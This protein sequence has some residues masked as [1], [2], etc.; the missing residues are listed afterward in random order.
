M[1]CFFFCIEFDI[2]FFC[3]T[4]CRIYS[5]SYIHSATSSEVLHI[6]LFASFVYCPILFPKKGELF[7]F[8]L[9]VRNLSLISSSVVVFFIMIT[10]Y[11]YLFFCQ[12]IFFCLCEVNLATCRFLYSACG[13]LEHRCLEQLSKQIW[14]RE[15]SCDVLLSFLVPI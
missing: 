14:V 7:D 15:T 13:F 4:F 6:F 9:Y 11:L 5:F 10:K 12:F 8:S 1:Y 2:S 3:D